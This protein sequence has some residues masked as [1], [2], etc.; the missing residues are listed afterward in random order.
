MMLTAPEGGIAGTVQLTGSKSESNRALLIA[1]LSMGKVEIKNLSEAEDTSTLQQELVKVGTYTAKG[2]LTLDIGP[3]GTA[4]RFLT[5]FL[6]LQQGEFLLTGSKR[7]KERPIALL[8]DALRHIGADIHYANENGYPPLH[9]SGPMQQKNKEVHIRGDVSSQY[10]SSLLLIASSLPKGLTLHIEGELTSR[11]YLNM[12]L[13][14]LAEVGIKHQWEGNAIHIAPQQAEETTIYVEPDW[15]AA[16]YWYAVVSL[17]ALGT[18]LYLPG[19]KAFSLQGDSTITQLM[20]HYGVASRFEEDG[21]KLTKVAPPCS[22]THFDL[23]ECPDLAQTLIVCSAALGIND[24]FSGLETLKIKET[25]RIVALQQEL[26]KFGVKLL[27]EHNSET[28]HLDTAKLS[29]PEKLV[30]KTYE[31]HRMAMAFAPLSVLFKQVWIEDPDV[32]GKSYPDYWKHLELLGFKANLES[33]IAP[34]NLS[35]SIH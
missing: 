1:A 33:G 11:P 5:G 23:R 17:S 2:L 28:Y 22:P 32:V 13:N 16:S 6:P 31:D 24:R 10:L 35:S 30:V 7:M 4:M 34:K 18:E 20:K 29:I 14:M 25:D 3:A 21:L 8:V 12:T 26:A 9:V 19:L 15:S 27:K